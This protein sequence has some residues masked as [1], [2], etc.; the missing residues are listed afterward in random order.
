MS[1]G[2]S[3]AKPRL[4]GW[5]AARLPGPGCPAPAARPRLPSRGTPDTG[6]NGNAQNALDGN[7][8]SREGDKHQAQDPCT[9]EAGS[10]PPSAFGAAVAWAT[11]VAGW[12]ATC[13]SARRAAHN[14]ASS[15]YAASPINAVSSAA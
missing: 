12:V 15:A 7:S 6:N 4:R 13:P 8:A 2:L 3:A 14:R 9:G 11:T 1:A 5:A 10:R